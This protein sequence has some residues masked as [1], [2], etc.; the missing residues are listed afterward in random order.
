MDLIFLPSPTHASQ[1]IIRN[2]LAQC[3]ILELGY[4]IA[5]LRF[6]AKLVLEHLIYSPLPPQSHRGPGDVNFSLPQPPL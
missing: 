6:T 1:F 3:P 4:L 5:V 2:Y